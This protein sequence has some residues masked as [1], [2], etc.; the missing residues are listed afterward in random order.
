MFMWCCEAD[1]AS[2]V[3]YRREYV[4]PV[5]HIHVKNARTKRKKDRGEES[6]SQLSGL[7]SA[8]ASVNGD[9]PEIEE[10]GM[11]KMASRI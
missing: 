1:V 6:G 4:A 2:Y 11:K 3:I 5:H 8:N 10:G 9:A 7:N